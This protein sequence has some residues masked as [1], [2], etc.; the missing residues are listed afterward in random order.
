MRVEGYRRKIMDLPGSIK[1][2]FSCTLIQQAQY[3]SPSDCKFFCSESVDGFIHVFC[4]ELDLSTKKGIKGGS[5]SKKI[6]PPC[7]NCPKYTKK[8]MKQVN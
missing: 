5:W 3:P 1:V 4:G 7:L 8:E 2:D 6:P